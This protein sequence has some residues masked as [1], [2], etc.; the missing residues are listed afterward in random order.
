[1]P[2]LQYYFENGY[3]VIFNKYIIENGTI[4]NRVSG[5]TLSY[6]KL[7]KYNM[8]GVKDDDGKHHYIRVGRAIASSIHG[9]PPT[10]NHSA[11]HIDKNPENDTDG[12]IRW[13]CKTGQ[14]KNQS[15]PKKF[16]S[17]FI[18]VRDGVE[19][20]LYGWADHLKNE[21]N[22]MGRAF[23]EDMIKKYVHRKLFGFSYKVY[24]DLPGEEWR[25]I[26]DSMNTQRRWEISNMCRIKLITKCAEHVFS[27]TQLCKRNGYPKI[28][29][30]DKTW[31]CHILAFMTFFPKEYA[32]KKPGECVL[33][34]DD[35][36]LDFRPHKLRL[37]TRAE[38]TT[39]ALNN[40][41][42]DGTK[43]AR[44]RCASYVGGVIEKEHESQS[45]AMRYL[46]SR[47]YE[48]ATV[49]KISDALRAF[50]NNEHIVKYDRTWKLIE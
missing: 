24:P 3:H 10:P 18:V 6:C 34:E 12:N 2:I 39:D 13:L 48:T 46:R 36:K 25:E 7:D 27:G 23:T 47:G 35:D 21:K 32:A 30:N 22:H 14:T 33:H 9:P 20:T 11:D 43:T 49:S 15:R 44:I 29:I 1:M 28:C 16:K 8:C 37:G 5:K 19:K 42:R 26:E 41:K 45:D 40:G 4:V 31:N 38:N 50:R 17:A